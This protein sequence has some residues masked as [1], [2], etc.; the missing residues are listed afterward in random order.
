MIL[1]PGFRIRLVGP[2]VPGC[3]RYPPTGRRAVSGAGRLVDSL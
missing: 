1:L 3:P 2:S